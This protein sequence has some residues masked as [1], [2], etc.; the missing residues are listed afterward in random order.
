MRDHGPFNIG[1][2]YVS[3]KGGEYLYDRFSRSIPPACA[4]GSGCSDWFSYVH[5]VATRGFSVVHLSHSSNTQEQL[6]ITSK[7]LASPIGVLTRAVARCFDDK[8]ATEKPP[9]DTAQKKFG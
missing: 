5:E 7:N 6:S 1:E 4:P 9:S 8:T 2:R 3:K